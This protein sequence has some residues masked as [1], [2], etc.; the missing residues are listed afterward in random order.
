[1]ELL[2]KH[3]DIVFARSL[4]N[5]PRTNEVMEVQENWAHRFLTGQIDIDTTLAEGDK[6]MKEIYL[7]Q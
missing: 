1:M 7:S 5:V 2:W 4:M 3:G 6:A